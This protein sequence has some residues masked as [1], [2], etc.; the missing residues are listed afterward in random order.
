MRFTFQ[1]LV[2]TLLSGLAAQQALALEVNYWP[3]FNGEREEDSHYSSWQWLGP[4][5]FRKETPDT[6]IHGVRPLFVRFNEKERDARSLHVLYPLFN[7][8]QWPYGNSWDVL[9]LLRFQSFT[10]RNTEESRTFQFFPFVFWHDD[11]E[12]E[13]SYFGVFPLAGQTRNFFSYDEV[14][15]FLFPLSARFERGETTTVALP[16]P[17][18][19]IV[20]GPETSGFHIWPL[21]GSVAR[22]NA[23]SRRYWLWPL[24]YNVRRELWKEQPLEAF[25]FLPFYSS[26][27]SERAESKTF[28]WPFF[29]YTASFEPHYRE[30]RFFWP[31][32]V[33]RRGTSYVNRWAPF[34]THSIREGVDLRWILWPLYRHSVWEERNLRNERTQ[35]LYFLYWSHTQSS[36]ADPDLAPAVKKHV[37]PFFS[38]W[39]N[40]AGRTQ[41]Q[42]LSPMEVFFPFNEVVRE[43][44]TPLFAL[45]RFDKEEDA[46][47]RHSFLFDFITTARDLE[48]GT[49]HCNIGPLFTYRRSE[50]GRHWELFKGLLSYSRAGE[51]RSFGAFW[52]NRPEAASEPAG[53]ET[54]NATTRE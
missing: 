52:L 22:E 11:P 14:S 38:S 50:K 25:G 30:T 33:Q 43:K 27:R 54:P 16:W 40:G 9:N 4:V 49:F 8:R 3:V 28:I 15:W 45:Y 7:A 42:A 48:E 51:D 36:I 47:S 20:R 39:D 19:R 13:K 6:A 53:E 44:Y 46:Y 2:L 23:F 37:W 10:P 29:G 12:P 18:L 32:F 34:Y 5:L 17:F 31:L 41:F 35:F 1:V 26:S 21:Y 24:G